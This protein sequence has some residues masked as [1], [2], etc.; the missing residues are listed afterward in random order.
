MK[1]KGCFLFM[2]NL[3]AVLFVLLSSP[4][5]AVDIF[6]MEVGN[7]WTYDGG[8][9]T[10]VNRIVRID[11]STFP[12]S[13]YLSDETKNGSP[14]QKYWYETTSGEMKL[15]GIEFEDDDGGF[16]QLKFSKGL[17]SA[18]WPMAVGQ[19]RFTSGTTTAVQLPGYIL[20]VS[21]TVNVLAKESVSLDFDTFEAYKI[22]YVIRL[23]GTVP[24]ESI[25]E[26]LTFHQWVVPYIGAVK[27]Q[28]DEDQEY[29]ISFGIEGGTITQNTDWDSDGLKDYEEL[30]IYETKWQDDDTDGDDCEDGVEVFVGRDPNTADPQGDVNADCAVNL[31]DA[32][33]A[34]Q[35]AAGMN[36][37]SIDL[38]A[39]VD[40]DGRL[41]LAEV[42]YILQE[43]SDL[44]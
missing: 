9:Y 33:L 35:V 2:L 8:S 42:V 1:K 40:D 3:F 24:G 5:W 28:D 29:L 22:G 25:D 39:D 19:D 31:E 16:L 37:G 18:W 44:R 14:Y 26:R 10:M 21:M 6:G 13:T 34:L 7:T 43:I 23:W 12:V 20:N 30:I 36:P 4:V 15:W 11:N 32:V 27:Y 17:V 41:S 38:D